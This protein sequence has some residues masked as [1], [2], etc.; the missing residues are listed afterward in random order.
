MYYPAVFFH[1]SRALNSIDSYEKNE[2]VQQADLLNDKHYRL[3][4]NISSIFI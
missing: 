1:N 3:F 4:F 2:Q